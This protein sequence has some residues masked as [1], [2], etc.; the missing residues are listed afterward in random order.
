M[1]AYLRW[2]YHHILSV[3]SYTLAELF[4]F[5]LI[6]LWYVQLIVC[7]MTWKSY[8]FAYTLH[9][10]II[11]IMQTCLKAWDIKNACQL[12]YLKHVSKIKLILSAII[13]GIYRLCVFSLFL[14]QKPDIRATDTF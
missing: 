7:I 12:Y 5:P 1:V 13:D 8:S 10:L 4:L 6:H 14:W 3:A 2:S 11:I 9:Y